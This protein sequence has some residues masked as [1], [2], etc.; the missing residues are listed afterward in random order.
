MEEHQ[1]QKSAK[2]AK[3]CSLKPSGQSKQMGS[4]QTKGSALIYFCRQQYEEQKI[5]DQQRKHEQEEKQKSERSVAGNRPK[6]SAKSV[7]CQKVQCKISAEIAD[8][9]DRGQKDC[10]IKQK[11]EAR[12]FEKRADGS[13]RTVQR[14]RDKIGGYALIV[15]SFR[16]CDQKSQCDQADTNEKMH[17]ASLKCNFQT[18]DTIG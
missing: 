10:R 8:Q 11:S 17:F 15:I 7:E 6:R 14:C 2:I 18:D 12:D 16:Q 4:T 1:E 3:K 5:N 13:V 9:I